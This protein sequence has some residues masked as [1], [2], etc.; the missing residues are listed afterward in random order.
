MKQQEE[1]FLVT[2]KINEGLEPTTF[3]VLAEDNSD[4]TTAHELVFKLSREKDKD[5][6][7]VLTPGADHQWQQLKGDF[8]R[9]EIDSIGA[10][11]DAH[12]S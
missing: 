10:A 11:I 2:V 4:I 3:S 6:L 1:T 7:A 8:N 12:Y 9:H 5:I